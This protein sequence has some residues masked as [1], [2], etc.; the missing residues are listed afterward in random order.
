MKRKRKRIG[1]FEWMNRLDDLYASCLEL[2]MAYAD[3][4]GPRPRRGSHGYCILQR[5]QKAIRRIE[6]VE[7]TVGR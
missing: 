2:Q 4:L 3:L 7:T 5:A 1:M 6:E